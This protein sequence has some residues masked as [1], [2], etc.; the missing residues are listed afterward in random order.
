MNLRLAAT[1][2]FCVF[3]IA[4]FWAATLNAQASFGQFAL[5]RFFQGLG[6]CRFSS[7]R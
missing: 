7:C 4:I 1:F 5:P 3:G 2:A 6:I